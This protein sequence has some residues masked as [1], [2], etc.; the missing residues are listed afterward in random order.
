MQHHAD[1]QG[2]NKGKR[3]LRAVTL[4]SDA[5]WSLWWVVVVVVVVLTR[6]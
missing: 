2:S 6:V 1:H 4:E 5:L 3:V